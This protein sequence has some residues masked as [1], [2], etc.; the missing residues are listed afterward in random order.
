LWENLANV[1]IISKTTVIDK[2]FVLNPQH[3]LMDRFSSMAG[4]GDYEASKLAAEID[5]QQR[6]GVGANDHNNK[7]VKHTGRK[8]A[9]HSLM[10]N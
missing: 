4:K 6:G 7:R 10:N 3:R 9:G 1:A 5:K 8:S 2:A